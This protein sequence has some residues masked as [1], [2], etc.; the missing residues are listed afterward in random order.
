MATYEAP[1][2]AL[3]HALTTAGDLPGLATLPGYESATPD[4]V[5]PILTEAGKL[6][7]NVVAPLNQPGDQVGA[8]LEE[9][10]VRL[11]DGFD[12]AYRQYVE[13]GWHALP[14]DPAHGGQGLPWT[15]ALALTEMWNSANMA[16]ALC[17]L[18]SVSAVELLQAHGTEWQ[19]A[20]F[21]PQLTSGEWT[22][23]MNLTE[24]QAGT[25]VGALTTRAVPAGDHYRIT[26]QKIYIT[27]GEHGMSENI[28]HMVL[29][30]TP[31]APAGTKGVSLFLVPKYLPDAAGA[32]GVRNDLRCVSLETK[33]GLHAS[34]TCTM[35]FGDAGGAVGYR[36][37]A[38]N[39]GM[40]AMFTMMNN[41]RL[42][43][44]VQGLGLAE[45]AYQ[46][47]RAHAFARV[48]SRAIDSRDPA[49][50]PIV[51]HPDVRRMLL[52]MKA[53]IAATRA[54]ALHAGNALDRAKRH[55]DAEARTAAQARVDL[56][57]P[58]VKAR[59]S[60]LGVRA[61]STAVQILGGMGYT[62]DMGV[63]QY[64]RDARIAPIY[65]GTNGVQ[66][67]DL[68]ARKV[69]RDDGAA[70]RALI[71][72]LETLAETLAEA[73]W[74]H[75]GTLH[76]AYRTGIETLATA[77]R[78]LL[79]RGQADIAGAAAVATAYLDL[80]GIVAGGVFLAHGAGAAQAH[81]ARF[82]ATHILPQ[83]EALAAQIRNGA[84][85]VTEV[86]L[87]DL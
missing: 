20:T 3:R 79:D 1:V 58:V 18:L 36:I 56:L 31:N 52:A 34:P 32:P 63:A 55:P 44:G 77:T 43:I 6:A 17:P 35:A 67:L 65:E 73:P 84:D 13:A 41:A 60:D 87:N 59:G 33:M 69:L 40:A 48:Q 4:L 27:H 23:T 8:R 21:L 38:E 25:D 26:G 49:S 82:Y 62:E 68:V 46:A 9:G 10:A 15:L 75:A 74:P 12:A 7:A 2:A 64:Y 53:E 29:A 16:W 5:D 61:S 57:T 47:A 70:A 11:P 22:G 86:P 76:R 28:V 51:R 50:V 66:A 81:L 83:A 39:G 54:L 30:R 14:F 19:K 85:P 37:G 78:T 71:A 42:N 45:R 80:L 24:P 72:E